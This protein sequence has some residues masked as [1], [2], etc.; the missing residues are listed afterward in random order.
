MSVGP[1]GGLTAGVA[2]TAL[3]Q[4]KSSDMERS[5]IDSSDH[6]RRVHSEE[7]AERASGIGE[8]DGK[9]HQTGERD[10][11]G[12]RLWEQ[13]DDGRQSEPSAEA[14]PAEATDTLQSKDPNGQAGN[15]LDLTG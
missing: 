4:L 12:R 11:D 15:L 14:G 2:G 9:D 1:L 3:A 7:R 8:T 6:E 13:M 5:Q 10:A